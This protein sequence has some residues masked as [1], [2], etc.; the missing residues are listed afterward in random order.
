MSNEAMTYNVAAETVEIAR[1]YGG[2]AW[3]VTRLR[4][5]RAGWRDH[6]FPDSPDRAGIKMQTV[7][8][9]ASS[10]YRRQNPEP[11][12]FRSAPLG[13]IE[14]TTRQEIFNVDR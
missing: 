5:R 13:C 1:P 11:V 8:Y 2:A 12:Q 10:Q 14:V 9:Q 7:R 3:T 4:S 6:D